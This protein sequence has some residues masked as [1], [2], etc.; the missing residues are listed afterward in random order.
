MKR[1]VL[2]RNIR[3]TASQHPGHFILLGRALVFF[4][5]QKIPVYLII[6]I[7][8]MRSNLLTTI[9]QNRFGQRGFFIKLLICQSIQKLFSIKCFYMKTSGPTRVSYRKKV[10]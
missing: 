4:P 1:R 7:F 5:G 6:L 8:L 3:Y 10:R 9:Y 2:Q